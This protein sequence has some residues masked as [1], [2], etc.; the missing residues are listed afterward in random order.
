MTMSQ[1]ASPL[2]MSWWTSTP[3]RSIS[4]GRR[5]G[6]PTTRTRAPMMFNKWMFERPTRLCSTSPQIATKSPLRRPL[7]RRI[8]SASSSAWVGCSWDPSPALITEHATFCANN[9]TAPE[10]GWRTMRTSGFMALSVIAVSITVS[11][12]LIEEF[13]T[14]MLMT[15]PP[16]LLPASSNEVR[17]RVESSKNRFI[18]VQPRSMSS[19]LAGPRLNSK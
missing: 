18:T 13:L 10:S 6:G 17:V 7:R 8:V 5:V 12:F 2:S 19:F 9:S 15:S 4:G 11:P 3:M 16:S 1:S 14:D